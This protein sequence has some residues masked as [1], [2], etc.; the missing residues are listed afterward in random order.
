MRQFLFCETGHDS[1][2]SGAIGPLPVV[3]RRP[4]EALQLQP[5]QRV[6]TLAVTERW[7]FDLLR[8]VDRNC[9]A[10]LLASAL[11]CSWSRQQP[12]RQLRNRT[13]VGAVG[14]HGDGTL[15][16]TGTWLP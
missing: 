14:A 2:R 13:I 8:R 1:S 6:S 7:L 3:C 10:L 16:L 12:Q 4:S 11:R 9:D 15:P 5:A